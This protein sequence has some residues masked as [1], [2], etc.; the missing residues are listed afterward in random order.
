M[1]SK[2]CSGSDESVHSFYTGADK[3]ECTRCK[4]LEACI[5]IA[6][7]S[8]KLNKFWVHSFFSA[9]GSNILNTL[10]VYSFL[11]HQEATT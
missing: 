8:N 6:P 1:A 2:M 10:W 4:L 11:M 7:G 3:E 9:P 5:W